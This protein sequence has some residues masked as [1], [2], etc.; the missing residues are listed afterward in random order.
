MGHD[1]P[2]IAADHLKMSSVRLWLSSSNDD[3][4][5]C[6]YPYKMEPIYSLDNM[7]GLDFFGRLELGADCRAI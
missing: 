6:K 7:T 5:Y 3:T 4:S 2:L 1:R